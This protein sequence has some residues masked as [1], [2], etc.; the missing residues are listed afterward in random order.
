MATSTDILS[1]T[2]QFQILL[3]RVTL[4]F[5]GKVTLLLLGK[6]TLLLLSKPPAFIIA[7]RQ[8]DKKNNHLLGVSP[9][10]SKEEKRPLARIKEANIKTKIIMIIF[11]FMKF[12]FIYFYPFIKG[13]I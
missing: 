11:Y 4:L 1:M 10:S 2:I 5:L 6:V 8:E 13:S 12:F 7:A 9:N 3:G